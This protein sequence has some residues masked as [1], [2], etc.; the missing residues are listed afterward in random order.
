MS[1]TVSEASLT[2]AVYFTIEIQT[3]LRASETRI[4]GAAASSNHQD[5]PFKRSGKPKIDYC[6]LNFHTYVSRS[7][8]RPDAAKRQQRPS[9]LARKMGHGQSIPNTNTYRSVCP[10]SGLF[11]HHFLLNSSKFKLK[12]FPKLKHF[13]GKLKVSEIFKLKLVDLLFF[14]A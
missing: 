12:L 6:S 3:V 8:R 14:S 4:V 11:F 1:G 9:P 10:T 5:R 13:F 7:Q 2:L